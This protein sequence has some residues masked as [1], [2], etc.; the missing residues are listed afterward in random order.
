MLLFVN[1]HP[2]PNIAYLTSTIS[3]NMMEYLKK[4]QKRASVQLAE[5]PEEATHDSENTEDQPVLSE[6]DELFLRRITSEPEGTP[7]ELPPRPQ[8]LPVTGETSGNDQQLVLHQSAV[9]SPLPSPSYGGNGQAA[10]LAAPSEIP[11]PKSPGLEPEHRSTKGKP[12]K[13]DKGKGKEKEKKDRWAFLRRG[14]G[15]KRKAAAADLQS[16]ADGPNRPG[17]ADK[18]EAAKEQEELAGV[19]EQLNLA[20]VNNRVFSMSAESR[21]LLRK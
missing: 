1:I 19:M 7:P 6:E 3:G 14:S 21:D 12:N 11:L 8:D 4:R 13:K 16:A 18:D 5:K 15:T 10:G 20:A 2:D 9:D 17:G